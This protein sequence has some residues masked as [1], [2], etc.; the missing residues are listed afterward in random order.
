M[1][2]RLKERIWLSFVLELLIAALCLFFGFAAS[3]LNELIIYGLIIACL[4]AARLLIGLL[5]ARRWWA[6]L[7]ALA[8]AGALFLFGQDVFVGLVG[9][10]V[11]N[12]L[13]E[14]LEGRWA[15]ILALVASVLLALIFPQAWGIYLGLVMGLILGFFGDVLVR[16][17]RREQR[18]LIVKDERI[19]ALETQL[20]SQRATISA[21]EQQ[22]RKAER[23]R[24]TARIHDKVGHGMTGSILMLEAAQLQLDKDPQAA[25]LSISTAT[26]NLRD[27]VDE[28]RRELREERATSEQA[29]LVRI[30]QTLDGFSA[31]HPGLSTELVTEGMLDALPQSIWSCVHECLQESL[32]NM[33]KHSNGDRFR[34]FIS[35][36]NRLV[37]VEFSD[38]G[39]GKE[40]DDK[41]KVVQGLGLTGIEE[42][43][44]LHGGK[45]FFSLGEQGFRTRMTFALR[46][47]MS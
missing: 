15:L 26:E 20:E 12:V 35:L 33:L 40:L 45:A 36:H 22:G 29:T 32:T 6:W 34:V 27:S 11:F 24:L 1:G 13:C 28:I 41:D 5:E 3:S 8:C 43:V 47:G 38:N 17:L 10:L 31:R 9:V 21:I 42:R 14:R 18:E 4:I 25:R 7:C 23:N 16:R 30:A 39:T 37:Y 2:K 46:G 19:A 44:L